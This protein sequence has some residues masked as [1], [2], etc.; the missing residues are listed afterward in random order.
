MNHYR[1]MYRLMELRG[2]ARYQTDFERQLLIASIGTIV[3]INS[4]P[5]KVL[6][7]STKSKTVLCSAE[8]QPPLFPRTT[9]MAR[10]FDDKAGRFHD[11]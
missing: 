9:G 1:G 2:P 6:F 7:V 10:G 5:P 8:R 4:Q 11:C 3:S